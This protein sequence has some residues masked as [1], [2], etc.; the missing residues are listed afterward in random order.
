MAPREYE[1]PGSSCE[2]ERQPASAL[3]DQT[4]FRDFPHSW[5]DGDMGIWGRMKSLY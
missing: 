1:Q 5:S 2:C 4:G 3:E